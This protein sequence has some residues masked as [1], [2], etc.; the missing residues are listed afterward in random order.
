MSIEQVYILLVED[1]PAD[2]ELTKEAFLLS[3]L[4]S[5]IAVIEDGAEVLPYLESK[6]EQGEQVPDLILLDINL[7]SLNGIEIL[8]LIKNHAVLK[9]MPVLMLTSSLDEQDIIKSYDH[10]CNGYIPKPV[11]FQG[12]AE[13]AKKIEGFW[14]DIAKL[15]IPSPK[16]SS[17]VQL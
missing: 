7:P 15:P 13:V 2:I 11:D 12:L 17:H 6:I 8:T 4:A 16:R 10:Y 9:N 5:N 3:S 14:F 1:N